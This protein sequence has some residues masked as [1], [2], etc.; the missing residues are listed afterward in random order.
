M[1]KVTN[2]IR[3][4]EEAK[5]FRDLREKQLKQM[6]NATS[7]YIH[8]QNLGKQHLRNKQRELMQQRLRQPLRGRVNQ[9]RSQINSSMPN[10]PTNPITLNN[11]EQREINSI[12]PNVPTKPINSEKIKEQGVEKALRGVGTIPTHLPTTSSGNKDKDAAAAAG[13]GNNNFEDLMNSET[14][15]SLDDSLINFNIDSANNVPRPKPFPITEPI[16]VK[17]AKVLYPKA[18][19]LYSDFDSHNNNIGSRNTN[20]SSSSS[21]SSGSSSSGRSSSGRSSSDN[22]SINIK[23]KDDPRFQK[24]F[25]MLRTGVPKS[26][27]ISEMETDGVDSFVLD[28]DPESIFNNNTISTF[29][30]NNNNNNN[31]RISALTNNANYNGTPN[32]ESIKPKD[33][34][35]EIKKKNQNNV[36]RKCL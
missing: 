21:S 26:A 12:M 28:A 27:V 25:T 14:N 34:L 20:S 13:I 9:T 31:N 29:T 1:S 35:K 19:E 23:I 15:S 5:K 2:R 22:T 24:Y 3:A 18:T 10:V 17:K 4:L 6:K 32:A 7:K 33:I 36:N 11:I 30:N 16:S 8:K